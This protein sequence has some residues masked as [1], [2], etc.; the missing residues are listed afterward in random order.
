[1]TCTGSDPAR[2]RPGAA[3]SPSL[4]AAASLFATACAS[5]G[6]DPI[7]RPTFLHEAEYKVSCS[8]S[9]ECRVQYI[10][11]AGALRAR[12]VVGE[13]SLSLGAD[14]GRRMWIRASGGG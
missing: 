8:I 10:D 1:M 14:P 7:P 12:D 2:R 5:G 6:A 11:E 4:F 13:W 9:D 3:I